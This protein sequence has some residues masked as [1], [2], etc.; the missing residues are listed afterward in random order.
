MHNHPNEHPK[1]VW[2]HTPL[3]WKIPLALIVI[4]NAIILTSLIINPNRDALFDFLDYTLTTITAMFLVYTFTLL[5][6]YK[7]AFIELHTEHYKH[8]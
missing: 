2:K 8:D 1:N 6:M 4:F 7:K 5:T 3:Y